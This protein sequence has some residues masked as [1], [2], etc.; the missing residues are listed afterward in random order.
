MELH[1]SVALVT[2]GAKGIGKA[3][4]A[5]MLRKGASVVFFDTD[6]EALEKTAAELK[7]ISEKLGYYAG[8]ICR[9]DDGRAAVK[10]A[11]DQFGGLDI[12]VNCAGIQTW[13][14]V[15]TT[16][17][18]VWDRTMNINLKGHWLMSKS[19]VPE[20]LKRGK[21]S[22]VNISSAQGLASQTN[23]MA[24]V[25]SK[26]AMIGLTRSMAVDLA[27]RGVRVNCVC[28]GTVDTP[29]IRHTISLDPDPPKLEDILNKM[30]P[31]GRIGKPEEI[32]EVV[33]FLAS[34][35]ASF[36]TGSIVTV[37]GGLLVPI[38]GSPKQD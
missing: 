26:H 33:A 29:M 11:V 1:G 6:R 27:S 30:H 3:S 13:G 5:S 15:L 37:D 20:M 31:L 10:M 23:V 28:P 19:A 38:A 22:I 18:E 12:L 9:P 21:G 4:G 2:G 25:T 8:D 36:M 24:Y 7:S 17:E 16:S 34:D 32:G 14:D 35:G